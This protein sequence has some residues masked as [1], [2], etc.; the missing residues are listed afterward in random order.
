MADTANGEAP[1]IEG[2]PGV[3]DL[4][5]TLEVGSLQLVH[6]RRH[7]LEQLGRRHR[8]RNCLVGPNVVAIS[9]HEKMVLGGKY[10]LEQ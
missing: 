10:H 3:I 8:S 2:M 5:A 7:G 6:H 1:L 4:K 9:Q